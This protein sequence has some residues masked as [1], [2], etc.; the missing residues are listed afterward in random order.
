MDN[1]VQLKDLTSYHRNK[2]MDRATSWRMG[3]HPAI[4]KLMS[5]YVK[6][7]HKLAQPAEPS[8]SL[9]FYPEKWNACNWLWFSQTILQKKVG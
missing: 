9:M 6:V 1:V 3:H 7:H 4:L 5:D 8:G 2:V